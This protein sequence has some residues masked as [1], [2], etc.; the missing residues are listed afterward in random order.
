MEARILALTAGGSTT[1]R[2]ATALGLTP[3]GAN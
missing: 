3:D 2:I 1:A